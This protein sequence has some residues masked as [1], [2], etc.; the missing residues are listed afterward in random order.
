M[1]RE[2]IMDALMIEADERAREQVYWSGWEKWLRGHLDIEREGLIEALGEALGQSRFDLRNEIEAKIN[3]QVKALELRIAELTG[4]VD[5][6]RGIQPPPPAKFPTIR[7]WRE[8]TIYHEGDIVAL[9]RRY[10]SGVARHC[11]RTGCAGLD[12]PRQPGQQSQYA[13]HLRRPCGLSLPRRHHDRRFEL[14]CV[15]G[16]ARPLPRPRLAA[17]GFARLAW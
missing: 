2:F 3:A 16:Q 14:R 4:A 15:E 9:C 5:I 7:A 6:L 13:R 8:D 17:L 10:I 1:A 11:A 12:L